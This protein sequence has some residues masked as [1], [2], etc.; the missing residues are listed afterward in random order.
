LQKILFILCFQLLAT[1]PNDKYKLP[2]EFTAKVIAIKDGD[3]IDV[4]YNN[5]V[6][7]IR[8]A[9]VD[10]PEIRKG[11]PYGRHAKQFT[12]ALCFKQ[13]VKVIHNNKFDRY[14]RLIATIINEENKNVNKTLVKAGLAWHFKKYSTNNDF[15]VLE[16]EARA[17]K[18]GL[19]KETNPIAPWE[20]RKPILSQK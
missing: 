17:N 18:M 11:Q 19:W 12:A 1:K 7:S 9:D 16:N 20:W 13:N 4:F 15:I 5:I 2:V 6:I 8:L 3:S 14:K 10:C